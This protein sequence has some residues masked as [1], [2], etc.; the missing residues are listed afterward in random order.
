V[1]ILKG[2]KVVC[3]DTLLQVW[4]LKG[5]EER[6]YVAKFEGRNV[7]LKGIKELNVEPPLEGWGR[8][9][10][11][12]RPDPFGVNAGEVADRRCV[13]A[14]TGKHSRKVSTG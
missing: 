14:N 5:L 8:R 13:A 10:T 3:F 9:R 12:R 7:G 6:W 1:F 4:I 2:V 11:R